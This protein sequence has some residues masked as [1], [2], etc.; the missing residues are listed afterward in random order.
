M[1]L[2]VKYYND[3]THAVYTLDSDPTVFAWGNTNASLNAFLYRSD[4]QQTYIKTGPLETDWELVGQGAY[5]DI[6]DAAGTLVTIGVKT[7]IQ[8]D[9]GYSA[10]GL[11]VGVPSHGVV[12]AIGDTTANGNPIQVIGAAP[13]VDPNGNGVSSS[14]G[15]K[16]DIL[17]ADQIACLDYN[18][19]IATSGVVNNFQATGN[20][21][22]VG[23]IAGGLTI[24]G[25]Q[26]DMSWTKIAPNGTFPTFFFFVSNIGADNLTLAHNNAGSTD[27]YRFIL[28]GAAN[29]VIPPNGGV[30]LRYGHCPNSPAASVLCW[31]L[32]AK[33]F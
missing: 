25:I 10:E 23:V 4:T 16:L 6:A 19:S 24:T 29:L 5:P 21:L 18:G 1:G 20:C 8:T 33:G 17:I 27:A 28:P 30:I 22:V 14:Q 26:P 13:T 31:N 7:Q 15:L 11:D 2:T 3:T 12:A 32:L 9:T